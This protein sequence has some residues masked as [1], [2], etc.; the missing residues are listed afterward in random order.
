[1][2]T[3]KGTDDTVTNQYLIK[4]HSELNKWNYGKYTQMTQELIYMQTDF[5]CKPYFCHVI[6]TVLTGFFGLIV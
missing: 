6:N 3:S 5:S 2:Y 4:K 1:M